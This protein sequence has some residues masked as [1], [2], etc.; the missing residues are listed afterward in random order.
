MKHPTQMDGPLFANIQRAGLFDLTVFYLATERITSMI[1]PELGYSPDWDIPVAEGYRCVPCPRRF[2]Q[3]MSFLYHDC[4][5][6]EKYDLVI[7]PGYARLDTNLLALAPHR[8]ALGM[9]LDTAPIYPEPRWKSWCKGMVLRRFFHRFAAFHPVGSLAEQFLK[10]L[11]VSPSKIFRYPY[12]VDNAYLAERARHFVK[13]REQWLQALGIQ[14]KAFVVLGVLKF[15]PRENPMELLKGFHLFHESFPDSA[16]I[17]VGAGPL[18]KAMEAH[19]TESKLDGAVRLVGYAKYS[20]LPKWYAISNVFVHPAKK[21]S[22]GVSVNEAMACGLPVVASSSVG[23]SYD[24]VH[25]GV[26]GYQYLT[27]DIKALADCLARIA[28]RAD[29]GR[30]LGERSRH[31]INAWDF[32]ATMKSLESALHMIRSEIAYGAAPGGVTR[33][34]QN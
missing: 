1:D 22:W 26:N 21:E 17:L 19:L 11:K 18:Q 14:S 27:G 15:V 12:A 16:L 32:E 33:G 23:S 7:I 29:R 34:Q 2:L 13:G 30:E 3:R 6:S 31:L 25:E 20:E 10:G 9:R 5:A 24:L 8:Q 28:S 4:L